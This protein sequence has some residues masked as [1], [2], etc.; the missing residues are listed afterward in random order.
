MT[1]NFSNIDNTEHS[2]IVSQGPPKCCTW[3]KIMRL[4]KISS[5][6]FFFL[7]ICEPL[8]LYL[9]Y[10]FIFSPCNSKAIFSREA[11][12]SYMRFLSPG[13]LKILPIIGKLE[14]KCY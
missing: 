3:L 7:F 8:G 6:P 10:I 5:Y 2:S 4:R 1:V 13:A 11:C 9:G 14:I 12:N